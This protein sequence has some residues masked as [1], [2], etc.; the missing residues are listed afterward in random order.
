MRWLRHGTLVLVVASFLLLVAMAV[1]RL[2]PQR[3]VR[4]PIPLGEASRQA[5]E[6]TPSSNRAVAPETVRRSPE[7]ELVAAA[8]EGDAGRV[9][10]LLRQ[11]M[12]PDTRSDTGQVA[13]HAAAAS[14]SLDVVRL[15]LD[16]G[17]DLDGPNGNGFT[18]LMV[19]AFAGAASSVADFI[20][21][22]ADINA[23]FEPHRVTALEQ[24]FAGWME[25]RG[26]TR[27]PLGPERRRIAELLFG[28]G[29][30]PNLGG[31]FGAPVRFLWELRRDEPMVRLFFDHGARL[32]D[33]PH[34]WPLERLPGPVGEMIREGVRA[35]QNR[36]PES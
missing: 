32:D 19:A 15:L 31:P 35:V 29:A 2:H 6:P 3:E 13:L 18:P 21:A 33:A 10:R 27:A 34:V 30:D 23:Q 9:R 17:A 8:H 14:A 25:S 1:Q 28:A 22:G 16:A 36:K 4:N 7:N 24:V 12:A 11:G 20:E 5:A 26:T